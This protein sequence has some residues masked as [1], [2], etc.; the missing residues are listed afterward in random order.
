MT[1]M[2]KLK[3]KRKRIK[4]KTAILMHSTFYENRK[5][6]EEKELKLKKLKEKWGVDVVV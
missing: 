6:R 2:T 4:S 5:I 1:I 3:K